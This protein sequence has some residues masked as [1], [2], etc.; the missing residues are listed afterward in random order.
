VIV[1]APTRRAWAVAAL[2]AAAALSLHATALG[3]RAH[4]RLRA[5]TLSGLRD[6]A[7]RAIP[8]LAPMASTGGPEAAGRVVGKV[9]ESGLAASAEAFA[10]DGTRLAADPPA[11]AFRHWPTPR[12]LGRVRAGEV[13]TATQLAVA[14]PRVLAYVAIPPERPTMVVRLSADAADLVADLRDRQEAFITQAIG[15]FLVLATAAL[16]APP[17]GEPA[18]ATSPG[19]LIAYE[20]AMGRMR[21]RDEE[22]LRQHQVERSR[23]EGE[24]RDKE[25]FVRAG[26]LTVGIVHEI[27]NGLGTIVGYA[28]LVQGAGGAV[29]EHA[30][31]IVEECETLA[32]V[33]RRFMEFAKDDALRPASFDLGRM[34]A[35]VAAREGLGEPRAPI[36]LPRAEVG[37]IEADEDLLERAFE[38]L[39]RNALDAAG[40]GGHVWIEAERAA[41]TVVVTVAD[42]GPGMPLD[43]RASLRPFFTTKSG[44]LGLGLPLAY[45]I[46]R[47]HGGELLL[48]ER[49]P[50]GLAVQV[51][52]PLT[53]STPGPSVTNRNPGAPEPGVRRNTPIDGSLNS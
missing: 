52:L 36:A 13:I 41:D 53:R 38:N 19:G 44:G 8:G 25:P 17:R 2:L 1:H 48:S 51:R 10:L 47:L 26:E 42:D 15:L 12:E 27:R 45:K 40:P 30:K 7:V 50:R 11:T 3:L 22:L 6:T 31:V 16:V 29:A 18:S 43:V 21:A 46:V 20:E 37:S 24:L 4:A 39:V 34:L 28:R 5:R 23:M 32:T 14:P 49:V 9:I 33:V 35:R